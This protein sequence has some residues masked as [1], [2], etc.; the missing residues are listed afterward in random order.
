MLFTLF[1]KNFRSKDELLLIII[2]GI[3]LLRLYMKK[4]NEMYCICR[5]KKREKERDELWKKLNELELER[6]GAITA[7]PNTPV[8]ASTAPVTRARP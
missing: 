8:P 2:V 6:R 4:S 1:D 5:E 7:A 3:E